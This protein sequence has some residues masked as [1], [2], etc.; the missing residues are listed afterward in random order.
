M[1]T[2]FLPD[3]KG[4]LELGARI[5]IETPYRRYHTTV[6]DVNEE[7][8]YVVIHTPKTAGDKTTTT[9]LPMAEIVSVSLEA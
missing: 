6:R 4:S 7:D 1:S 2:A 3:L 5:T 9:V 8:E